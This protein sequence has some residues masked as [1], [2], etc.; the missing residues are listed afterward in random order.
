MF[1]LAAMHHPQQHIADILRALMRRGR[2]QSNIFQMFMLLC[3]HGY[4]DLS[5]I[6]RPVD[7]NDFRSQDQWLQSTLMAFSSFHE[8]SERGKKM[9]HLDDGMVD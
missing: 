1:V 5:A 2:H 9:A 7:F 8:L 6:S 3:L 4:C